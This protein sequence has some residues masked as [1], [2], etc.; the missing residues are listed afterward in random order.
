MMDERTS[1]MRPELM[2]V[3]CTTRFNAIHHWPDAPA[4][5]GWLAYPHHHEFQVRA[6]VVVADEDRDVEFLLLAR[7]IDERIE[8][9]VGEETLTWSCEHYAIWIADVLADEGFDV[10]EVQVSEEGLHGARY[11]PPK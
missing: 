1:T 10:F 2:T 8:P 4:E 11:C 9:K 5:C 3:W 6:E 7:L